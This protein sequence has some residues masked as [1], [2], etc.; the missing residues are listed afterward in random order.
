MGDIAKEAGRE[1]SI[2]TAKA[3]GK[4]VGVWI[5]VSIV[6]AI[7]GLLLAVFHGFGLSP[8][9]IDRAI[10]GFIVG[11][12]GSALSAIVYFRELALARLRGPAVISINLGDPHTIVMREGLERQHGRIEHAFKDFSAAY[13]EALQSWSEMDRLT[14]RTQLQTTLEAS[15]DFGAG[16]NR[17]TKEEI[18]I[19]KSQLLT[20]I[21]ALRRELIALAPLLQVRFDES[22]NP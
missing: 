21:D 3:A 5:G 12:I 17:P 11:F 1:F 13:S 2:A 16:P 7:G 4:T 9:W 22:K 19:K 15:L 6:S 20:D 14:N 8:I 10:T 18:R